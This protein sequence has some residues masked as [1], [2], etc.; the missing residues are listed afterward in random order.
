MDQKHPKTYF[1][2]FKSK[3]CTLQDKAQKLTNKLQYAH[4]SKHCKTLR[5]V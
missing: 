3:E 5:S 1:S 4:K 2:Q